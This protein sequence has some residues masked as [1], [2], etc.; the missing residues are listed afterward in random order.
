MQPV[1]ADY[2]TNVS[3]IKENTDNVQAVEVS[4]DDL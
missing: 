2:V 1:F 3:D 4:I